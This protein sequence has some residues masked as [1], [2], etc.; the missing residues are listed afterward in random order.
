MSVPNPSANARKFEKPVKWLLGRELLAGLKYIAAYSFMG[1][2]FDA[3]DWMHTKA[4]EKAP[5]IDAVA[6]DPEAAP[7]IGTQ[8]AEA[9]YWFDFIADTGDG[10]LAVYNIAQLCMRDLWLDTNAAPG[11]TDAVALA[12]DEKHPGKLP[13]G[14]FLFVGGDIAYHIADVASLKQRFQTPFNWAYDDLTQTGHA[15]DK[16]PI[17]AIPA[18]HDYYDALDG[19]NRQFRKPFGTTDGQIPLK[20]FKSKQEA[21][22]VALKLPFGW[23]LWGFDSQN[24]EMDLRQQDFFKNCSPQIPDKLIIVTPEPITVFGKWQSDKAE[25]VNTFNALNIPTNFLP[26]QPALPQQQCRLDLSGDIHHYERYWATP[27]TPNYAS[28]VAGGG[29]A[30][31]HPSHT[32]L[33]EVQQEAAYPPH[34]QSHQLSINSLL[35]PYT[36]FNGGFIWLAGLIV[37]LLGYFAAVVPDSTWSLFELIPN[38]GRPLSFPDQGPLAELL[39]RVQGDLTVAISSAA[40]VGGSDLL[41]IVAYIALVL[42]WILCLRNLDKPDPDSL[43][44]S[45]QKQLGKLSPRHQRWLMVGSILLT[46]LPLVVWLRDGH[47]Q[48][49]HPFAA[50][51]LTELFTVA[52]IALLVL[53]RTY[54]DLLNRD[55]KTAGFTGLKLYPLRLFA[56]VLAP[57]YTGFGFLHYGVYP[58]AATTLNMLILLIAILLCA[59]LP[60]LAYFVGGAL[61]RGKKEAERLGLPYQNK[62]VFLLIGLWHAVLQVATPLYLTL[63]ASYTHIALFAV[64]AIA[65][66]FAA[67]RHFN[68]DQNGWNLFIA[69][70]AL[71]AVVILP[72][73]LGA[74]QEV[75][76]WRM[77]TAAGL[78]LVF[79]CVWFGWYL[80]VSLAFNGHNNEAGGGARSEGYRH[81][82]RF[83][84]RQN[85]LTAYV[86]GIDAPHSPEEFNVD[87]PK[88]RLVDNFII[89][90]QKENP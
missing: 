70:F 39:D 56:G 48:T 55:A 81:M 16:R 90:L 57:L 34:F 19:F 11:S 36:V 13:R 71:G 43:L 9:V 44:F 2:K 47:P 86:I 10:M 68:T 23:H 28:V 58:A 69:W 22:Y 18:N 83:A 74:P 49:L 27:Q 50:S 7:N 6:I 8:S 59:G 54:S 15:V 80:A 26:N 5:N 42:L 67:R 61:L 76:I 31:L 66:T 45:I 32:N 29:G 14:E 25:I 24:G 84:V 64:V 3:R 21:S 85:S 37:G 78:G 79:S 62:W 30:F 89:S 1:D 73:L 75:T 52:A 38:E 65:A 60:A 35:N 72:A 77:L 41:Y 20:G 4:N 63:Y 51:A 87:K 40:S 88:F 33:N 12:T 17:Y 82:I 46:S 53:N